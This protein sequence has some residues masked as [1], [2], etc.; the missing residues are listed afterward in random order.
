MIITSW[1]QSPS[2]IIWIHY[3]TTSP[4]RNYSVSA[5]STVL[6]LWRE[7]CFTAG[8]VQYRS[9][10]WIASRQRETRTFKTHSAE[11][12]SGEREQSA[13]DVPSPHATF[14]DSHRALDETIINSQQKINPVSCQAWDRVRWHVEKM[15]VKRWKCSSITAIKR[16][17]KVS[18][19]D[20]VALAE[21]EKETLELWLKRENTKQH[22]KDR[23]AMCVSKMG[24]GFFLCL[25]DAADEHLMQYFLATYHLSYVTSTNHSPQR[26]K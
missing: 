7:V 9:E 10:I 14:T 18:C 25:K 15:N 17:S 21:R 22:L 8:F 6:L 1:I 5:M 19:A 13:A 4:L 26:K 3:L 23:M 11:P 2:W 16:R 12:P 24:N 20:C